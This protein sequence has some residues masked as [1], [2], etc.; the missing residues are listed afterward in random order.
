MSKTVLVTGGTG[1]IAA[2]CIV[3]LLQRGYV[4]RTTVRNLDKAPVLRARIGAHVAVEDRL[5]FFAADLTR[6]AGWD[7]AV[8]GCDYVLHV[9]S[10]MGHTV[11]K[12]PNALIVP[13]RDGALRVLRAAC[14]ANVARVVMTSA[15][16]ACRPPLFSADGTSDERRWTDISEPQLGPY[17]LAKAISERAAWDFMAGQSGPTSLTTIL[18]VAVLGPVFSAESLGSTQ[19]VSRLLDGRLPGIPNM[20]FCVVDVRDLA[21]LH[22][23]A[24]TAPEAAGERFIAASDWVWWRADVARMLRT[25]LGEQASKV[26]KRGM[27]GMLLRVASVFDR[28]MKFV[29]PLLGRKHVFSA[30]KAQAALGWQPRP[31]QT[32]ILD[33]AQS[34]IANGAV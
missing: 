33:C 26:P 20:G 13:A 34:L 28:Q 1:F 6:D 29:I 18:P 21:D 4:V 5:T 17:R 3:E 23:R 2:W 10:P 12:D 31:V 25:G 7:N 24:M 9:A 22:I 15:V 11:P 32:T 8:A 14:H 16:E 27:P 19:L 30:A